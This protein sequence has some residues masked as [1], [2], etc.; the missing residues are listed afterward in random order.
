MSSP[1]IYCV[2]TSEELTFLNSFAEVIDFFEKKSKENDSVLE[3]YKWRAT[4]GYAYYL[5]LSK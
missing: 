5:T 2:V 4:G 3:V 1:T